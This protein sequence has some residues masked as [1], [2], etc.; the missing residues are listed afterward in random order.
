MDEREI[1]SEFQRVH[2][3]PTDA[4]APLLAESIEEG[5]HFIEVVGWS[6]FSN[7]LRGKRTTHWC[8]EPIHQPLRASTRC[9]GTRGYHPGVLPRIDANC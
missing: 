8:C 1:M 9:S 2:R 6:G 5:F 4:L 3:L 7:R